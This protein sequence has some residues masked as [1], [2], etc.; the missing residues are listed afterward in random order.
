MKYYLGID[1]GLTGAAALMDVHGG[2]VGVFDLPVI[3]DG[4]LAWISAPQFYNDLGDLMHKPVPSV[5]YGQLE[6]WLERSQASPQMG[7]S[8][9]FNYGV[10]FGSVLGILMS[11]A[12]IPIHF[13]TPAK[14]KKG[15]GL[16]G[17]KN[18]SLDKARLM[19]P[20]A[21]LDLAKHHGRAEAILIAHWARTSSWKPQ[22]AP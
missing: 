7:R 15:I 19:Y 9:A 2:F 10:G 22:G 4:A 16:S 6:A 1:P 12:A 3:R 14:W 5:M 11:R 21:E 18:A 8:S 13:V 20:T 17:D